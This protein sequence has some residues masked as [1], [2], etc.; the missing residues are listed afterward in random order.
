MALWWVVRENRTTREIM[1]K[2]YFRTNAALCS[3]RRT[4]QAPARVGVENRGCRGGQWVSCTPPVQPITD[5][6]KPCCRTIQVGSSCAARPSVSC[7]CSFLG[8]EY[9]S[10]KQGLLSMVTC[11]VTL[12][13]EN[14]PGF[15]KHILTVSCC[16]LMLK[17]KHI[18]F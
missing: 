18:K 7:K 16:F 1:A 14:L 17:Y 3:S 9:Q 6:K 5:A 15:E 8:P 10:K 13:L 11:F 4:V 12:A 2:Q